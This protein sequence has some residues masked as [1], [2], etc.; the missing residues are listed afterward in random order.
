MVSVQRLFIV[1]LLLPIL[2]SCE[3]DLE[4]EL[5]AGQPNLVVNSLFGQDS[6]FQIEISTTAD[7]G[8][9]NALTS[10]S[11]A[12]ITLTED[13]IAISDFVLDSSSALPWY[14]LEADRT[15]E[16]TFYF[17]RTAFSR[18]RAGREYKIEVAYPGYETAEATATVP[19]AARLTFEPERGVTNL[20]LEGRDLMEVRFSIVDDGHPHYYAIE[21]VSVLGDAA[22]EEK[23]EFYSFETAFSPNLVDAGN[24]SGE[25]VWYYTDEGV[26]F[27]NAQFMGVEKEFSIFVDSDRLVGKDDLQLRIVSL[28]EEFFEFARSYQQQQLNA[29]NPFAEPVPVYSNVENGLGIFA[30]FAVS[31]VK[32]N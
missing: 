2:V 21:L 25:G 26:Y 3:R 29:G 13:G 32:L 30:G 16:Q 11:D 28:S 1:I 8:Q 24:V 6:L 19:R 17:Y 4:F 15:I 22:N 12:A 23:I 9:G 20:L 31:E 5:R 7:L 14:P 18:V 10:L 27:S